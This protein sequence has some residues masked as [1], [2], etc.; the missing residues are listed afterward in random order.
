MESMMPW[1]KELEVA[2]SA[3]KKAAQLA[4]RLQPN[5]VAETK[6]DNSPV[7]QA[8]R[9]CE[10]LIAGMLSEGFPGDGILGEEGARGES[11]NGR[12]WIV[13]PIDGTRD[14]VR[15]NAL[16]ANLIALE[17]DGEV[18]AGVVNLPVLGKLYTAARGGGAHCNGVSIRS[19]SKTTPEESV[20]CFNRFDKLEQLPP[21]DAL[22]QWMARFWSLRGLG[23]APD[24]MMVASGQAE[25]WIEP[26]ASTWDFAPL[27]VILEEAGARYFNFDGGSSIYAGNCVACAPGLE[28]EARRSLRIP[29]RSSAS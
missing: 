22:M 9:E 3:A 17:A 14:F 20:L 29:E 24:A 2:V 13:D 1:S 16:W 28:A 27:K 4:L 12:K 5:I 25:I 11:T 21:R 19:S 18:V 10:R 7:T 23:G 15:G 26:S 8:D 6:A